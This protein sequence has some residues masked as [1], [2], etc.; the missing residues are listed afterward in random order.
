M[1]KIK[2]NFATQKQEADGNDIID[3]RQNKIKRFFE[4]I[5]SVIGWLYIVVYVVYIIYGMIAKL[6]RLP[7]IKIGIYN[8]YMIIETM[9]YFKILFIVILISIIII[10]FWRFYNA[11]RYGKMKRRSFPKASNNTE[12]SEYF[13]IDESV[14]VRMQNEKIITLEN[15]IV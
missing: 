11:K 4:I 7:V 10:A 9:S 15:N 2:N 14:V 6:F 12:L 1:L 8:D 5:L 3:G 13:N